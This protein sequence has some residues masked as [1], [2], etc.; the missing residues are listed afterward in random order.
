M[1]P[2]ESGVEA[3]ESEAGDP[4]T[5]RGGPSVRRDRV[6]K[7]IAPKHAAG[8][9]TALAGSRSEKTRREYAAQWSRFEAWVREH[10]YG[11]ALPASSESV[12]AYLTTRAEGVGFATVLITR[13]AI[14]AAHRDAELADPTSHPRVRRVLAGLRRTKAR[15][16]AP[17][18]AKAL[19]A[20]ELAQIARTALA[21]RRLGS[22]LERPWT[23]R[24]RAAADIALASVMRDAMLRPSEAAALRW[25]DIR[26][27][28]NG[29]GNVAVRSSKTDQ[30]G[31]GA[32]LYLG[33]AAAG[34]LRAHLENSASGA[35]DPVFPGRRG[36]FTSTATISNRIRAMCRAAGLGE[37]FSG[38]SPRI[39]MARDLVSAGASLVA[40]QV[41]GRWKSPRM[42][43][44]YARSELASSGAVAEYYGER[45]SGR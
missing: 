38:H 20:I 19:R 7:V 44:Y 5:H 23:T 34:A 25:R 39:G 12:A 8:I 24:V 30:E 42:P 31:V 18:Q 17:K 33:R 2:T 36:G 9:A 11:L 35:N 16:A 45:Q 43:A 27:L 28:A 32:V 14:G 1:R 41:A 10:E 26:F 37:G 22:G 3:R 13:A 21:P 15:A 29:S 4:S 6:T 40:V